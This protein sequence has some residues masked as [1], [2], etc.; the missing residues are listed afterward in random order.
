MKLRDHHP[1][2]RP[3]LVGTKSIQFH[4]SAGGVANL[5]VSCGATAKI[6]FNAPDDVWKIVV[7][8][9]YQNKVLCVDCFGK[10]ACEK[11]IKLLQL[12]RSGGVA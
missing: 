9:K 4:L 10:F 3:Q 2:N 11:Q 5:C 1:L 7:P 12:H 8:T 6:D